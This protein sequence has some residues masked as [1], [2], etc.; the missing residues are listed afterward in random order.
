MKCCSIQAKDQKQG[1]EFSVK[2]QEELNRLQIQ[3]D[4][5]LSELHKD[6][7]SKL[8]KMRDSL[9]EKWLLDHGH[10]GVSGDVPY[11]VY[12]KK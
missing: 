3:A 4:M 12:T 10:D 6:Y 11:T 8:N 2:A 1:I 9:E 7:Q 5:E